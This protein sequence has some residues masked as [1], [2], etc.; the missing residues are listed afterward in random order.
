[1]V[2]ELFIIEK[3]GEIAVKNL[4]SVGVGRRGGEMKGNVGRGG[5]QAAALFSKKTGK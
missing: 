1:M 4:V 3:K 2:F 5:R